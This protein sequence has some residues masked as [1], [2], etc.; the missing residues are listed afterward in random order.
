MGY[1]SGAKC[2]RRIL[3]ALTMKKLYHIAGVCGRLIF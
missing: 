1:N 2:G 3:L